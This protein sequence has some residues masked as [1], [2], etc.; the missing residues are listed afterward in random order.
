ME[1]NKLTVMHNKHDQI[2]SLLLAFCVVSL[3]LFVGA[4][5]VGMNTGADVGLILKVSGITC[6]M[7]GLGA[8]GMEYFEGGKL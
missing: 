8:L 7:C 6:A 3:I 2:T 4:C 5:L 1:E